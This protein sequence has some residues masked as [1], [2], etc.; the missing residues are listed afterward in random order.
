MI[1][2]FQTGDVTFAPEDQEYFEKRFLTLK[3]YLGWEAGDDDTVDV[4]IKLEKNKHHTGERF[5]ASS[6]IIAPHGGKFHAEISAENI[7]KCAD[8][9][10]DKLKPQITKFHEKHC[11]K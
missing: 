8:E 6:T 11:E 4:K 2:H 7:K 1:F 3:K 10:H 5:E 9:L